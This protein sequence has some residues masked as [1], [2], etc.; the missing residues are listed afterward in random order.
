[1][2]DLSVWEDILVFNFYFLKFLLSFCLFLLE[3][4]FCFCMHVIV[5]SNFIVLDL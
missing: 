1:M 4:K 2:C 5:V 3:K